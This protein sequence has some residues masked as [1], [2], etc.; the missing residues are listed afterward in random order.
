MP[1]EI[2]HI[3]DTIGRAS[4]SVRIGHTLSITALNTDGSPVRSNIGSDAPK[5]VVKIGFEATREITSL[6]M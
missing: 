1:D 2:V 4:E 3:L 5:D 6:I